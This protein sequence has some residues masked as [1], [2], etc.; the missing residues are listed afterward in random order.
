VLADYIGCGHP[1]GRC[2]HI[3]A[4][5]L[6][7]RARFSPRPGNGVDTNVS[8]SV[9]NNHPV[10]RAV[11]IG[12]LCVFR[13]CLMLYT[14]CRPLQSTICSRAAGGMWQNRVR[15]NIAISVFDKTRN[16]IIV[17]NTR[18][19]NNKPPL[20]STISLYVYGF[21]IR[22]TRVRGG[23]LEFVILR[24][25]SNFTNWF[26]ILWASQTFINQSFRNLQHTMHCE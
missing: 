7:E 22:L 15:G 9:Y 1:G 17:C 8:F 21:I 12:L 23:G 10:V 3:C 20:P 11:C 6:N 4:I 24:R 14:R 19:Y 5:K 26:Y 16:D 25:F 13:A 18:K 2:I